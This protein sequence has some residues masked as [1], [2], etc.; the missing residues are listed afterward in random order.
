MKD[1]KIDIDPKKLPKHIA[2]IMD[3]N[4]RWARDKGLPRSEGHRAGVEAIRGVIEACLELKIKYLTLYAFSTENWKRPKKEIDSLMSLL[5]FYLKRELD[6]LHNKNVKIR[7]IGEISGLPQGVQNELNKAIKKTLNNSGLFLN[8]ALNYGGRAEIIRAV[9]NICKEVLE[10]KVKIE[11]INEDSF[12]NYLYTADSPDPDLLIRPSGELRI[13]NFLI[14]QI[15][16]TEFWFSKVYWPDFEKKH[17]LEAIYEY[18]QRNRR[19][20]G[21]K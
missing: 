15:A 1:L 21:I 3:G 7:I 8:V 17:L 12:R 13:S 18:Q 9:K 20:G 19:F 4:G 6:K 10:N 16:Y 14:W 2:I 5:V 11:D